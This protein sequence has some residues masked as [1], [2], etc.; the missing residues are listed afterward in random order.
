MH[1]YFA[2]QF[3]HLLLDRELKDLEFA[4]AH[5]SEEDILNLQGILKDYETNWGTFI[6]GIDTGVGK[7]LISSIFTE[8]LASYW[9]PI[10]CGELSYRHSLLKLNK[11]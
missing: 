11:Q 9:K 5:I 2:F 3:I 7:T 1:K 8:A 4:H 6:T 10:Q